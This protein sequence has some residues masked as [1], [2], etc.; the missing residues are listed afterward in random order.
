MKSR[1]KYLL[2]DDEIKKIYSKYSSES[3]DK[4]N[5]LSN[6]EFNSVYL[7]ESNDQKYVLKVGTNLLIDVMPHEKN[8]I[9]NEVF[10]YKKIK[11][12]TNINI[13]DILYHN[14]TKEIINADYFIMSYINGNELDI[15]KLETTNKLNAINEKMKIIA[16]FHNIKSDKFGYITDRLFENWYDAIKNMVTNIKDKSL[17]LGKDIF[18]S[19][20]LLDFIE[21]N[22]EVLI[23]V[24]SSAVFFDLWDSNILIDDNDYYVIDP[25][26]C[27]YGDPICDFVA[28]VFTQTLEEGRDSILLYNQYS[29]NKIEINNETEIRY[30]VAL[31]YLALIME[32]E[33]YL[34]YEEDHELYKRNDGISKWLFSL[35]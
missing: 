6:G 15:D 8:M 10:W 18:N 1:T 22:K 17:S 21:I 14:T 16:D 7:I 26:R 13:P 35:I 19:N 34:R 5:V 23:N 30:K 25:E 24:Q 32:V 20:R 12:H 2:T 27:F 31:G 4:I 28:T 11:E 9:S 3:I 29:Q 33:K